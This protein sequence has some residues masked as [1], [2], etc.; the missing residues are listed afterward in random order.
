MDSLTRNQL[1]WMAPAAWAQIE[2]LI[3]DGQARTILAH[4]RTQRLPVVVC[5]QRPLT[6]PEQLCV[7]LPAPQQWSRRRL[8]L[9]V[10]LDHLT[11]R[12]DFPALLQVAQVHQWG[13]AALGLSEALAAMGVQAHVYGSHG[14]QWLTGLAYLHEASDLDVSVAVNSLEVASQVV[15]QLANTALHC[16]IDGEIVFPQ[17]QAIAWRELQQL[18]QGQTSQVLVK[19]RYTL[20]L[21]SLPEVIRMG[22]ITPAGKPEAVLFNT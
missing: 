19:D 16:R 1:V 5:R 12:K 22:H 10:R 17:G 7:G 13:A 18:L 14:W 20:R 4:W 6:P 21:A 9:T 11:D 15:K 8:A 3:W 2:A